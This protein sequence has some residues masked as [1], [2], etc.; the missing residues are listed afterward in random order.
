M[1]LLALGYRRQK[2]I[3][4]DR[5]AINQLMGGFFSSVSFMVFTSN[6]ISVSHARRVTPS[7]DS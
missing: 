2:T 1:V 3:M 7:L 6:K 5:I 4:N